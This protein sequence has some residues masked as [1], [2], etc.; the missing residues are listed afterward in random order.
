MTFR[1]DVFRWVSVFLPLLGACSKAQLEAAKEQFDDEIE[2]VA[3]A[4]I[5]FTMQHTRY[6]PELGEFTELSPPPTKRN[7]AVVHELGGQLYVLGGLN[8]SGEYVKV[9]DR[10]DGATESWQSAAPWPRP[11]L[12]FSAKV[13]DQLCMFA[14]YQNLDEPLRKEVD[15]YDASSDEWFSG[16]DLPEAYSSAYPA[17]LGDRIYIAGGSDE[18]FDLLRS[19]WSYAPGEPQWR[20]EVDLPEGRALAGVQAVGDELYVFGGFTA[21]TFDPERTGQRQAQTLLAFDP[22]ENT[23]SARAAPRYGRALY[24]I[25]DVQGQLAVFF[26]TT[27]GALIELYDPETNSWRDGAPP[28][29]PPRVGLYVVAQLDGELYLMAAID[30]ASSTS[31]GSTNNLWN[32]DTAANSWSIVAKRSDEYQDALFTGAQHHD[33]IHWIGAHTSIVIDRNAPS[34]GVGSGGVGSGGVGSGGMA[35]TSPSVN[36]T[37]EVVVDATVTAPGSMPDAGPEPAGDV[38]DGGH[39]SGAD[40]GVTA[41][42]AAGPRE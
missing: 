2:A 6:D 1:S 4:D 5:V 41:A 15:C 34:G 3:N 7:P 21:E 36:V 25:A 11:G 20:R 13:G 39:D 42:G 33:G 16:P 40:A 14:G 9:V 38:V 18:N 29:K 10:Y 27:T 37:V 24:G 23:W 35:P 32:F 22:A 26:G 12:A 17:V 31:A 19:V 8:E 28:P 30:S